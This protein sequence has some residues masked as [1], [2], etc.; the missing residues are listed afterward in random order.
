MSRLDNFR[1]SM[2]NITVI[3][4]KKNKKLFKLKIIKS[5][6]AVLQNAYFLKFKE[7]FNM[8]SDPNIHVTKSKMFIILFLLSIGRQNRHQSNIN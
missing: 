8:S 5:Q 2:N 6:F 1:S 7:I 4:K 3:K